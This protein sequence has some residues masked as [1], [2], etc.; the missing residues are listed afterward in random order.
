MG[1][2]VAPLITVAA[3]VI[4]WEVLV[5]PTVRWWRYQQYRRGRR[6]SPR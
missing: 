4:G 3:A 6:P 1:S 2:V 5:M